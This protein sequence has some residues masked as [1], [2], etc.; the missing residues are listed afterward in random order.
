MA[1]RTGGSVR[2]HRPKRPRWHTPVLWTGV[3]LTA[4]AAVAVIVL[5]VARPGCSGDA[6]NI[7]VASSAS[8]F[9]VLT[10]LARDWTDE[11]PDVDGQCVGARVV[12]KG[13]SEVAATLAPA[14]DEARDGPRPDVWVPDSRL[15]MLVAASRPDAAGLLPAESPSIATSQVVL[16]LRRPVAQALG[17]P[18]RPLG[19]EEVLGVFAQPQLWQGLGHPEYATLRMGLTDPTVST[20]GLASTLALLDS[21]ADGRLS[22]R[23]LTAGVGFTQLVGSIAPDTTV[24]IEEQREAESNPAAVVAV[25]PVL[26]REIAAYD[27]TKPD[28]ELVPIYARQGP[29]VADFPY[30]ILKA[31]WVDAR[32]QAAAGLFL[33]YLR[34]KH[35]QDAFAADGFRDA[36]QEIRPASQ[37]PPELGFAAKVAPARPIPD[38]AALSQLITEWA[39]LQRQSNILAVL[40]TS[41]SMNDGVPG[42][43]LTRLQLLQQTAQAG[44]ALLNNESKIGLWQFSANLTPNSHYRELVPYGP[45]SGTVGGVSRKQALAGAVQGLK[46]VGGTGLYDTAWAAFL[47]IKDRWEPNDTNAIL[48]ITDGKNQVSGGLSLPQLLSRLGGEARADRPI[49]I[50]SIAVGPEADANA[51]REISKVTGGRTFVVKDAETAVQTLVLA[52][53]G[54]LS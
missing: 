49:P 40:D 23:E 26:E 50:I 33:E 13:S 15:W 11:K 45:L 1:P 9:S 22:D 2:T 54:R 16:A 25:F 42:T 38:A 17:W 44:F 53:A 27:A 47:A 48:L 34:G 28:L 3:V 8:Q 39:A 6:T 32:R 29:I 5:V 7:T 31:D 24:F 21:D 19:W 12:L 20:A 43:R 41:G 46:A 30:A 14:W 52:F 36:E 18:Q 4:V 35:A 51:L 10:E 37:L